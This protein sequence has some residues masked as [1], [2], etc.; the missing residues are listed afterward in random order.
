MTSYVA[1]LR[2]VNVGRANRIAMAELR[3]LLAGVGFIG[4]RTYLQSGNAVFEAAE[5]GE[6]ELA[7]RVERALAQQAGLAV[8]CLVRDGP[9]VRAAVEGNLLSHVAT[10]GSKL[11]VLFLSSTPDPD[12]VAAHDPRGLAPE[13]IAIGERV[14]YQWCPD[15]VRNA[16]PLDPFVRHW[17]VDV[18][19][20]NWNTVTKLVAMLAE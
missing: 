15:G 20:R 17:N 6:P 3:E 16:P 7:R 10:D 18:T 14:V 2:G 13:H 5:A 11:L 8:R 4:V 12:L 19:A 9:G 1:L